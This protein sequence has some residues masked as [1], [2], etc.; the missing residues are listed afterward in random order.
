MEDYVFSIL[1]KDNW[2]ECMASFHG[3]FAKTESI[4][5]YAGLTEEDSRAFFNPIKDL[6][7]AG[8]SQIA[9][10][11]YGEV[12]G[13][14]LTID[15]FDFHQ[16]LA[17]LSFPRSLEILFYTMHEVEANHIPVPTQS[18][19]W[20]RFYALLVREDHQRKGL[21]TEI[22]KRNLELQKH[23]GYLGC[24]VVS[25]SEYN[26][27]IMLKC[28]SKFMNTL[29]YKDIVYDG[30]PLYPTADPQLGVY[31]HLFHFK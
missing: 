16:K 13:W 21:G 15:W 3:L 24:M 2:D 11:K 20:C 23:K 18:G 27:Q 6:L 12:V 19:Q 7:C 31:L 26:H 17:T 9:K 28:G 25:T 1:T 29:K 5:R 14:R 22:T 8:L 30:Q 10:N 4:S